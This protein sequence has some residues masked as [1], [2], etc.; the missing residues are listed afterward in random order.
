LKTTVIDSAYIGLVCGAC[1]A[2]LG[3]LAERAG[4]DIEPAGIKGPGIE[5][6]GIG[7]EA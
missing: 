3:N 1:F 6:Q 2:E 5:Y 4:A 7:R